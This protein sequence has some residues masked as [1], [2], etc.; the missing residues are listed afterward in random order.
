MSGTINGPAAETPS[1]LLLPLTPK[2]ACH[3]GAEELGRFS[4]DLPPPIPSAAAGV[5]WLGRD[6][7]C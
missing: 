7:F 2:R 3:L 4:P 6:S 1:L 5:S